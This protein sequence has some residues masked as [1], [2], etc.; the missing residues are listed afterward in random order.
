MKSEFSRTLPRP[1]EWD[2]SEAVFAALEEAAVAWFEAERVASEDRKTTRVA[3]LRYEGQGAELAITWPGSA[4]LAQAEFARTHQ[5]LNGFTLDAK[6]ELVTLRVEAEGTVP[7]PARPELLFGAGVQPNGRQV[8]HDA[9]GS[10]EAL[11]Y[12]RADFGAGD[13]FVGPAIV[14]Q[15]DATT[16]VARGW[17]AAVLST[18]ALLLRR[19]C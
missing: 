11:V 9:A 5:T 7:A 18:G 12:D 13:R 16:V 19:E 4:A 17:Q 6:V 1:D 2:A 8:V 14:T 15:L 10:V 3:L